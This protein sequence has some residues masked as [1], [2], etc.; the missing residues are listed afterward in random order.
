[1]APTG[2]GLRDVA[3]AEF[4]DREFRRDATDDAGD[5]PEPL[6]PCGDAS[7]AATNRALRGFCRFCLF[8]NLM[9]PSLLSKL[10]RCLT[11]SGVRQSA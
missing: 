10:R 5:T 3:V 6:R 7:A 9:A 11:P 2:D 1:M 8:S 4:F